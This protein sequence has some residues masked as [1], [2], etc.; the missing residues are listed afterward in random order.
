MNI[1]YLD[2]FS[3]ISGDMFLGA[4]LDAGLPFGQ[5][6]ACLGT[7]PLEHYRVFEGREERHHISGTR[8]RVEFDPHA[9]PARTLREIREILSEGSLSE[10]V[11][12]GSLEV[13]DALARVEGEIHGIPAEEVHFHEVGA[14]DSI[15]DIVGALYGL[16]TL[17]VKALYVSALPLGSGF[18]RTAHGII[19]IPAPATLGL[20]RDVPVYSSGVAH[21]MVTPTGAALVTRL[22]KAFGPMPSMVVRRVGYGVGSR[23]LEDRPNLARIVI[24][25][26]EPEHAENTVV[27]IETN[28]DDMNPEW[29]GHLMDRLFEQGALD[30]VMAPVQMKKNRPAVQVQ[31]MGHP[32]QRDALMDVLFAETTALGVRYQYTD[33]KVLPRAHAVVESPWGTI[34]VKQSFRADGAPCFLPEY[35]ACRE[36]ALK[37]GRPLKEIYYWIQG[38]NRP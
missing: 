7:L 38:L 15:I 20:L 16:E 17:G 30:V 26:D 4:L 37:T 2:C 21:E 18:G 28:L 5:L 29:M 13:F 32:H 9:Q 25:D 23:D 33:R 14:V 22:A 11:R 19:P 3:G 31:V 36:L 34:R 35:E 24:G 6:E 27:M 1:A 12:N 10:W 8:F